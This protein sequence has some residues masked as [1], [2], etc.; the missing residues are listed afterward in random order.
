MSY[1]LKQYDLELLKFD[2]VRAFDGLII[3]IISVNE[4]YR[5]LLPLG[6]I[7]DD[8]HLKDWI[9]N[10][11][12]PTNRAYVVNL[13]AHLGLNEKDTI[14]IIEICKGL[15]LNDSYWIVETTLKGDFDHY[16]LYENKFNSLVA[17][18]ALTG[19]GTFK[20][21]VLRSSPEF[22]TNGM[23]AKCWRRING[24]ILLFKS[25]TEGFA[26]S[27][28]EPYSE[29]YAYQVANAMGLNA[30][31][32][33]LSLWKNRLCSTCELFTDID[34]SFVPIGQLVTEGGIRAVL[35]YCQQLGDDY[36]QSVIDMLVF[37]AVICNTD[38]HFGNFGCLIN[39]KTNTIISLAP[40]FDHGLSLFNYATDNDLSDI[41]RYAKTRIPC[42]YPDFIQFAKQTMTTR[43]RSKLLQLSNFQ[44]K[45]HSRYNLSDHRL[46]ILAGFIQERVKILLEND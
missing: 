39:N 32:Y 35:N 25:G 44:F 21:S 17:A 41:N 11:T 42:T 23:L 16:N 10:R 12:I 28:N 43:Q 13:L 8:E 36:Y 37:D 34:T 30:V 29:Y 27:G 46:K 6:L 19:F 15:S 22:T 40:L 14:G 20:R 31:P 24:K 2:M 45:K 26:N 4:E 38:R 7:L 3:K 18:F 9:I 1:Y 33:N 5:H